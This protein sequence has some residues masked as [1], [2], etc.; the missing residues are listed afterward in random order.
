MSTLH[1]FE[2]SVSLNEHGAARVH[3]DLAHLRVYEIRRDWAEKRQDDL[4]AHTGY[5]FPAARCWK[6]VSVRGR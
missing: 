3:H 6:Y 4:K 2:A 5:T 1:G